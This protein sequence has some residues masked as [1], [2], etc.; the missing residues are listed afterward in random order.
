[1]RLAVIGDTA[2][3]RDDAGE[4][5]ALAPVVAQL[6]QLAELFD[7]YLL[8]A[9]LHE[10][11]P[12]ANF[13]RYPTAPVAFVALS[14]G[15]GTTRRAKARLAWQAAGWWRATRR[16]ARQSDVLHFRCPSNVAAVGLV[17]TWC[18]KR[19]RYAMYAGDWSGY[20]NEPL[21]YR[22]QR[23]LLARRRFGGVVTV[24]GRKQG[25]WPHVKSFYS[26]SFSRA[27]WEAE[28]ERVETKL[29]ALERGAA[30]GE[31]RLVSVGALREN[32]GH[33]LVIDAVALLRARGHDA[34]LEVIGDGPDLAGLRGKVAAAGL[35]HAVAL[36]GARPLAAV[37]SAFARSDIAVL[38]SAAEGYPKVVLEAMAGAAVPI[39]SRFSA[40]DEMTAGGE[41]GVV[42]DRDAE[43]IASAVEGLVTDRPRMARIAR[44]GRD[45]AGA[46]TLE[47][48]GRDLDDLLSAQVDRPL[49]SRTRLRVLQVVDMLDVGGR[50]RLVIDLARSFADRGLGSHV[51]ETRRR[52]ALAT[53]LDPR[54]EH[55]VLERRRSVDLR[56]LR[57][58][59]SYV[60]D[61]RIDVI[62]SHGRSVAEFVAAAG[63]LFRVHAPHVFHDHLGGVDESTPASP[64][65]RLAVRWG[66]DG[67]VAVSDELGS[68]ARRRL[69]VPRDR[70]WVVPNGI[71]FDRFAGA[72][73]VDLWESASLPP[74]GLRAVAVGNVRPPKDYET[75]LRAAAAMTAPV[76]LVIV[77]SEGDPPSDYARRCRALADEL[78]IAPRV[79][80]AGVRTDVPNIL[81]AA[82]VGVMTSRHES[83]PLSVGEF[84]AAGMPVVATRTGDLTDALAG[85]P[86]CTVVDVGDVAGVAAALDDVAILTPAQRRASGAK[87]QAAA[88]ERLS[89]DRMVD[90]IVR[91]Y[92]SL[93][94]SSGLT[95]RPVQGDPAG[96]QPSR[97]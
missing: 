12:P 8:C 44:A 88:A 20:E 89:L 56:A 57:A 49:R 1:M 94:A 14:P 58:F 70:V 60:R 35:Q 7:D 79:S 13:A 54:V 67:V 11:S 73:P 43:A 90:D 85:L 92:D 15:G 75:L 41:R 37:R 4:L 82:D 40:A 65:L 68:W 38:A 16:V 71:P 2:H 83:G 9:P 77:G 31:V 72:S 18:F 32:K 25:D 96:D 51:C 53:A 91:I 78:G 76:S 97:S 84:A 26:A 34:R 42:V 59:A 74:A 86:G 28:R 33:V 87:L 22:A 23:W 95:I 69:S 61:N 6:T 47:A 27:Q 36:E 52:G 17:A 48:F 39:V 19:M 80:F 21:S 55:L 24:Y 62:H 30:P 93:V 64:R 50:E 10:G 29:S 3:Y 66:V 5:Y 46:H 81:A 45:Y 63:F